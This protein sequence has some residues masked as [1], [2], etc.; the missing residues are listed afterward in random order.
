MCLAAFVRW[1]GNFRWARI[2][3]A[4]VGVLAVLVAA[5]L[6]ARARRLTHAESALMLVP[7]PG[8]GLP[9]VMLGG[10]LLLLSLHIGRHR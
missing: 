7:R 1:R 3:Q 5:Q 8:I 6:Y 4:V 10:G 2:T 9:I